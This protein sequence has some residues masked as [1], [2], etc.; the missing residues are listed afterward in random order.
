MRSTRFLLVSTAAAALS[1]TAAT[2]AFAQQSS[3]TSAT[4]MSTHADST[5][6]NKRDRSSE[7]LKPTDQP[8]DKADIKLAAAVRRAIV[9]DKS[10]SSS[11]HN[12][13]LVAANGVVTLRGP[14]KDAGEKAKV[15][16]LVKTIS[17]VSTVDNQLDIKD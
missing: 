5:A 12:L 14:V 17:G 3:A 2:C 4:P 8:N 1:L 10:L 7:T 13:K 11:A 15:E 6:V 16:A 9:K